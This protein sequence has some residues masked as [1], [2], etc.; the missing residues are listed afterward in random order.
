VKDACKKSHPRR[1]SAHE[2]APVETDHVAVEARRRAAKKE[3][4]ASRGLLRAG[5]HLLKRIMSP[6][7]RA[8]GSV[9]SSAPASASR[10]FDDDTLRMYSCKMHSMDRAWG[11]V[12]LLVARVELQNT[13]HISL[14]DAAERATHDD[15]LRMYC[16]AI[17]DICDCYLLCSLSGCLMCRS[18]YRSRTGRE[19]AL[20][21][22][23]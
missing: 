22:S 10:R 17:H 2:R 5:V 8:G 3:Q 4:C 12:L 19:P 23:T 9:S 18:Q 13:P 7:R 20:E 14:L 1:K 16:C 6:S 11:A 21:S 15:T